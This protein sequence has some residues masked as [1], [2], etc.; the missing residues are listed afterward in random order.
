MTDKGHSSYYPG[1]RRPAGVDPTRPHTPIVGADP[2]QATYRS[3]PDGGQH[4]LVMGE[5]DTVPGLLVEWRKSPG[6]LWQGRV[7]YPE[8]VSGAWVTVSAWLR[9]T[10]FEPVGGPT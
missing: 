7:L 1:A 3:V 8:Y 2:E 9:S 5:H 10:L 6:H 4:V